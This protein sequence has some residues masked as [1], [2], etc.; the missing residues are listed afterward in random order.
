MRHL[1]TAAR[2]LP[3]LADSA[4]LRYVTFV[5]L[6]VAQGVPGGVAF[7]AIPAWLAMNGKT[8]AEIAGYL[9]VATLPASFKILFAPLVE[10]FTYLPMGRRRP[11][12]LVGQVGLTLSFAGLAFV[13]DPLHNLPWLTALSFAGLAFSMLQ[14]VATDSLAIDIIPAEQQGQANSLMWGAKAIGNSAA[15]AAGSLLINTYGLA[16]AVLLIAGLVLLIL[17][18]PLLLRE[19]AGEKLL[20]WTAGA[21]APESRR[22]RATGWAPLLRATWRVLLLPNSLRLALALFTAMVGVGY[23]GTA[24]PIF[25]I[26][27]LH[28]TNVAYAEIGATAGLV[29]GAAGML[30]GGL[31]SRRLGVVRLGQGSLLGF[32]G[33]MVVLGSGA[34]WWGHTS[35][36]VGLLGGLTLMAVFSNIGNLALAM[37]CCWAR[38]SAVQFTLYMALLNTGDTAGTAL[39]GV[40]RSRYSWEVTFWLVPALVLVPVALLQ[41]IGLPAHARQVAALETEHLDREAAAAAVVPVMA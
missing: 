18:V 24:L 20:P 36:V 7:G 30:V 35:V 22:L 21:P 29:A 33:L 4:R 26:Q 8:P 37:Q 27:K 1:P 17:P 28:W 31:L 12:L 32:A 3:A 25:L 5:L 6:Y 16:V 39:L 19:R 23:A 13:P 34:A 9:A 40:V 15:L 10:R 41:S 11:W 38:V 2:P 14:D